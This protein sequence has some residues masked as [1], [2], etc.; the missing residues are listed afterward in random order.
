MPSR[1]NELMRSLS[2]EVPRN[3]LAID[4]EATGFAADYDVPID[5]GHVLVRDGV[6][7]HRGSVLLN[8]VEHPAVDLF[9]LKNQLARVDQG[10]R[11]KQNVPFAYSIE[12]LRAEGKSPEHVL[13]FYY[14]LLRANRQ[15]A[16]VIVGHNILRFDARML[17]NTMQE[18][19]GLSCDFGGSEIFDTGAFVKAFRRGVAAWDGETLRKFSTRALNQGGATK[20]SL[21]ECF[22]AHELA[23]RFDFSSVAWHTAGF[24]AYVTHLIFEDLVSGIFDDQHIPRNRP[25]ISR[26]HRDS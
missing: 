19:V 13:R 16:G 7:V 18:F 3:Y 9:W 10:M 17:A 26:G 22:D 1:F 2:L 21:Q 23:T 11:Q 14:K 15:A 4:L 6:V 25:G 8:W 5:I 24:D 20:W 12:R